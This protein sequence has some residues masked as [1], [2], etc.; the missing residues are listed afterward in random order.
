M[1]LLFVVVAAVLTEVA[2]VMLVRKLHDR[3]IHQ[4]FSRALSRFGG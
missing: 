1:N 3:S 2:F 4:A